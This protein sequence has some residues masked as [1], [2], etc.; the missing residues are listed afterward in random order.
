LRKMWGWV[1]S[2]NHRYPLGALVALGIL[3]GVLGLAGFNFALEE[4]STYDFCVSCHQDMVVHFE[5]T[6]HGRNGAG[7]LATCSDCHLPKPFVP[8]MQRKVIALREVYH[9]LLGTIATPERFKAHHLRMA[10][11]VWVEM[12]HTDS[13]EC[14]DCHSTERWDL[15]AQSERARDFHGLPLEKGKTCID[16][17]KGLAHTLPEGIEPDAQ[18]PGMDF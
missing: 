8:K 4:T 15:A 10:S 18:L 17:H 5:A 1:A 13:R 14:R 7:F 11:N 16:C 12:N 6:P 3:L 9:H 2:P